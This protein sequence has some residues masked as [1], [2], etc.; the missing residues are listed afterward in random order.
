MSLDLKA[1]DNNLARLHKDVEKL[2]AWKIEM[3]LERK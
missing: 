3:E 1:Y 2:K